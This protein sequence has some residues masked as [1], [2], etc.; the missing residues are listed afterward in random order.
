MNI[1]IELYMYIERLSGIQQFCFNDF[2]SEMNL[3]FNFFY[4]VRLKRKY[5]GTQN[6]AI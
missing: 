4:L 2:Q 6:T 1:V 5:T 3:K